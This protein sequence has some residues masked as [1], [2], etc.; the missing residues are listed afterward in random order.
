MIP[1]MP[2]TFSPNLSMDKYL[3]DNSIVIRGDFESDVC[4]IVNELDLSITIY[5]HSQFVF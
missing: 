5:L 4:E 3:F 1:S 2:R